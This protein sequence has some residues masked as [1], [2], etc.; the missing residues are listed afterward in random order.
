MF[1]VVVETGNL[2]EIFDSVSISLP[3]GWSS[4]LLY[5]QQER[6]GAHSAGVGPSKSRSKSYLVHFFRLQEG[7]IKKERVK[8]RSQYEPRPSKYILLDRTMTMAR[9]CIVPDDELDTLSGYSLYLW[10]LESWKAIH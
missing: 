2:P 8:K 3:F 1:Y 9:P 4:R 5:N 10:S 7:R 6:K